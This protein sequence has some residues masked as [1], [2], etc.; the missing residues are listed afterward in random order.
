MTAKEL[1]E[2]YGGGQIC[3]VVGR[4]YR[5][6]GYNT[7]DESRIAYEHRTGMIL[8]AFTN[9]DFYHMLPNLPPDWRGYSANIDVFNWS[10]AIVPSNGCNLCCKCGNFYESRKKHKPECGK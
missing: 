10:R 4:Y 2:R 9:D 3:D 1:F 8:A 6:C 5:F 7:H